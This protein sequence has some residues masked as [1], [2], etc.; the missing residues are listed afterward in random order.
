MSFSGIVI[1]SVAVKCLNCQEKEE[2]E[3]EGRGRSSAEWK[4]EEG[5]E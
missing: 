5:H 4:L 1:V 2:S 3:N